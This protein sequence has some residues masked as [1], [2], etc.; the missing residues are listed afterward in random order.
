MSN[1]NKKHQNSNHNPGYK[2]NK[3]FVHNTNR[4]NPNNNKPNT[5]SNNNNAKLL[6]ENNN[7]KQEVTALK[8]EIS[9]L[10]TEIQSL[11]TD[12][13]NKVAAKAAEAQQLVNKK[14]QE[15]Q[16]RFKDDVDSKINSYIEKKFSPFLDCI[17]QLAT[18]INSNVSNPEIKN[19][20]LGF[21]MILDLFY[22][23]LEEMDIFCVDI[24]VGDVFNENYMSAFEVV[25]NTNGASNTVA[26]V[27]SPAYK[28]HDKVIKHAI[29]KVQK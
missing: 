21:K 20:L 9:K 18:I 12:Y 27:M 24:K 3:K 8:Q 22:R 15:L 10:Q 28:F 17:N 19:Y 13:I 25:D 14:Q 6:V 7:L 23:S 1:N 16:E 4:P 29:V 2:P 11:N 26:Q 5:N